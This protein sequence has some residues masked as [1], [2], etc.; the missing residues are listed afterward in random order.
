[1][2]E[3]NIAKIIVNKRKEK[4]LTQE[5]LANHIGVTIAAV[6]KWE[7]AQSYP[8]ISLLPQL[9]AYF[10]ISIDNLM[11]YEPQMAKKDI[12]KLYRRLYED[13]N[14]KPF[15][16][17]IAE[18]RQAVKKY[19]S[20]FPLLLNMGDLLIHASA[21]NGDDDTFF[22]LTAEAKALFVRVK[23]ESDDV[24]LVKAALYMEAM[25]AMILDK[26]DEVIG[27]L[28]KTVVHEQ[29]PASLIAAAYDMQDKHAEAETILQVGIY[30]HV[31]SAFDLLTS[32]IA[33]AQNDAERFDEVVRR[34]LSLVELFN[35]K[36]LQPPQIGFYVSAAQGYL[37]NQNAEQALDMLEQYAEVVTGG[38]IGPSKGDSF[39]NLI[40]AWLRN[41]VIESPAVPHKAVMEQLACEIMR[42]PVFDVL[43]DNP[44]FQTI[45]KRLEALT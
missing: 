20:C 21:I 19:Y 45:V 42:E 16:E 41:P 2:K 1:M 5:E 3:I 8:D 4:G 13:L 33:L 37:V 27:L 38:M 44:R 12:G 6:S 36:Q 9:A 15:E 43:R 28:E 31:L 11:G 26:P 30:Q 14:S 23:T 40:D 35:M 18:C 29:S 24:E 10:N 17:V 25:C 32:Y 34:T 7:T 39:F 22:A